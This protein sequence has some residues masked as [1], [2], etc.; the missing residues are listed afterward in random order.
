MNR[1]LTD[2]TIQSQS[3]IGNNGNERGTPHSQELQNWNL[4]IGCN[5]VSF[6][7]L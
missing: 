3:G 7:R 2:I 6:P 4:T 1:I 5:L